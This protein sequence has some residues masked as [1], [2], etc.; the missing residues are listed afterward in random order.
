MDDSRRLYFEIKRGYTP[1]KYGDSS[2]FLKHPSEC[3][4][5]ELGGEYDRLLK[6]AI[7]RKIPT[8]QEKI[9]F[10]IKR[11]WWTSEKE[12]KIDILEKTIQTNRKTIT[13]LT[14]ASDKDRL[15]A[16][17]DK[18]VALLNAFFLERSSLIKDTAEDYATQAY[19]DKY[20]LLF[21]F[22]DKDCVEPYF[23]RDYDD[24]PIEVASQFHEVISLFSID[25]LEKLGASLFF[26]DII[27]G[28]NSLYEFW[29]NFAVNCSHYQVQTFNFGK[30]FNEFIKHHYTERLSEVI[31]N[32]TE[33]IAYVNDTLGSNAK[34]REKNDEKVKE[35][36]EGSLVLFTN[37]KKD[38]EKMGVRNTSGKLFEAARKNGGKISLRG[39][40]S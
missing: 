11:G 13:Q 40:A 6:L 5:G 1:L 32:P 29:G 31:G 38:L 12:R 30:R 23:D 17:I 2:V 16:E 18:D 19:F 3:E 35:K 25:N 7:S 34:Q 22:R 24:V 10:C 4:V 27:K 37:D 21:L 8:R 39:M 28:A 9:A 20:L 33:F 14:Y 36:K 26:I 15:R